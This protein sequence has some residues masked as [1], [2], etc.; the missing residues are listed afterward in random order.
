MD[1]IQTKYGVIPTRITAKVPLKAEEKEE[2]RGGFK[3][4][5]IDSGRSG[6]EIGIYRCNKCNY[7]LPSDK[8]LFGTEAWCP[9]C[10]K[11]MKI[12]DSISRSEVAR[13]VSR[14]AVYVCPK[15]RRV[16]KDPVPYCICGYKQ[17]MK[18]G[19]VLE[20]SKPQHHIIGRSKYV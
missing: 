12:A 8:K 11:L 17:K 14:Q 9:K 19:E 6:Y 13:I 15:C 3:K 7:E 20:M 5:V 18:E 1:D 2:W 10:G 4:S 16:Y